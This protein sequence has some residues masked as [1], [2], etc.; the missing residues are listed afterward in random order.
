M[1]L[2]RPEPAPTDRSNFERHI[3]SVEAAVTNVLQEND[4]DMHLVLQDGPAHSVAESPNA[5]FCLG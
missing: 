3:Y 1:G 4:Q 5:P 2:K